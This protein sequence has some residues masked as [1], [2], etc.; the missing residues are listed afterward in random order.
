MQFV[1]TVVELLHVNVSQTT[2]ET[3]MLP[4]DL[5]V[6]PMQNAHPTKH[7]KT[8][9]V[10][11]HAQLPIVES[12]LSVKWS[13]IFPT[14]SAYKDILETPSQHVANLLLS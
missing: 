9:I 10:L 14:V 5:N 11:T 12:M 8:C 13:I 1:R 6:Q 4:A 2:S 7:V 3:L